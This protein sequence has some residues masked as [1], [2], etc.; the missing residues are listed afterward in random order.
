MACYHGSLHFG[1][2]ART[3]HDP[4]TLWYALCQFRHPDEGTQNSKT[5]SVDAP[6]CHAFAFCATPR[7]ERPLMNHSLLTTYRIGWQDGH[8]TAQAGLFSEAQATL[9]AR[10]YMELAV[11]VWGLTPRAGVRLLYAYQAGYIRAGACQEGV[12]PAVMPPLA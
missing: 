8:D 12:P 3:V 4:R 7:T 9:D 11:L 2:A 6:I 10:L 1:M 5:G